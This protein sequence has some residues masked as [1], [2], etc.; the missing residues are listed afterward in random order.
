MGT[1][2]PCKEGLVR[3]RRGVPGARL[4]LAVQESVAHAVHIGGAANTTEALMSAMD[5]TSGSPEA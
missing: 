1:G 4:E 3:G 5:W 2:L